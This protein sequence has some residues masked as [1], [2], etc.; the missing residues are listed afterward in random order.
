MS[1]AGLVT[2]AARGLDTDLS[3]PVAAVERPFE[4]LSRRDNLASPSTAGFCRSANPR[5]RPATPRV[6][7]HF[8][9]I[10]G[11]QSTASG[12]RL[13]DPVSD[14]VSGAPSCH[15]A[16]SFVVIGARR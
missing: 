8:K 14:P 1:A 11:G 4:T 9:R 16:L 13:V 5:D 10:R 3:W 12:T 15:R 6:S 7:E 2:G